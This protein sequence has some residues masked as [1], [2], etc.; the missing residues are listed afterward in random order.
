MTVKEF[1][2]AVDI[3]IQVGCELDYEEF[4]AYENIF[5]FPLFRSIPLDEEGNEKLAIQYNPDTGEENWF[6]S[7]EERVNIRIEDGNK[8]ITPELLEKILLKVIKTLEP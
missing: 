5:G 6:Y 8:E 3:L 7:P 4:L 1:K 2:K